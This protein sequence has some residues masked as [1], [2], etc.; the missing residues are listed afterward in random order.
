MIMTDR[1]KTIANAIQATTRA[2]GVPKDILCSRVRDTPT[3]LARGCLVL[4]IRGRY[5]SNPYGISTTYLGKFLNRDH[6]TIIHIQR[7]AG[8]WLDDHEH[9]FEDRYNIALQNFLSLQEP[10]TEDDYDKTWSQWD[11]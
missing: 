2:F 5:N 7:S 1:E 11:Y 3:V 6:S 9:I 10:V 8:L 4:L